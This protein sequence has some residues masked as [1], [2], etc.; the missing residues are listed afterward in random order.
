MF[1]WM[2]HPMLVSK[3]LEVGI[4]MNRKVY[5]LGPG[6]YHKW[7]YY[8]YKWPS[9][10]LHRLF[11]PEGKDHRPI[12]LEF[13]GDHFCYCSPL[14]KHDNRKKQGTQPFW[15][16]ISYEKWRYFSHCHTMVLRCV[17]FFGD[18]SCQ[19]RPPGFGYPSGH[20]KPAHICA[21]QQFLCSP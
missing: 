1:F 7:R 9:M 16:C 17:G 15:R 12:P 4:L 3:G 20:H 10:T 6:S 8:P 13:W 21:P 2:F 14:K 18:F 19:S 11:A 5:K